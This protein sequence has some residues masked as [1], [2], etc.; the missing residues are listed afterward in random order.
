LI[1]GGA[2]VEDIKYMIARKLADKHG[3]WMMTG[4][5]KQRLMIINEDLKK[6]GLEELPIS[7]DV[8]G[9]EEKPA[10]KTLAE[11]FAAEDENA[12]KT[13]AEICEYD[14]SVGEVDL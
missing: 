14:P 13:L 12:G 8:E 2:S 10:G 9:V 7:F 4:E 6:L 5:P 11:V 1:E 3:T